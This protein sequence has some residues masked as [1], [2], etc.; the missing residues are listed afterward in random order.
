MAR[1]HVFALSDAAVVLSRPSTGSTLLSDYWWMT[2]P[3]VNFLIAVT[4]AAGFNMGTSVTPSPVPWVALVPTLVGTLLVASGAAALN[5]WMEYPFD[6]KMRRTARRAIAAGRIDPI[7]ALL[8]GALLSL[9]GLTYMFLA[10]GA[11]PSWL[12]LATLVGY[13]CFYT[14]LKRRTPLCTLV[15]AIP[16]AVPP[17]IGWTAAS[18]HL[19]PEAWVLFLIVFLWQFPHFMSIAWMYKDDYA[20]ASYLVLPGHRT[21]QRFAIVQTLLPLAGLLPVS[22]LPVRAGEASS[23]YSVGA[24][25]L[26]VGFLYVGAQFAVRVS[27]SA[28]RRLL[29]ASIIYLPA[30][31]ALMTFL[32]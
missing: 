15:G 11:L 7:H 3:E 24:V 21:R 12:A 30:L 23:L 27:P 13:L 29:M 5:Q 10:V 1:E 17:L 9:A 20:R 22:L 19:D 8:F 18:G 32:A 28:A 16:G 4:T 25:V 6:A 26:G 14:P 31:L 2:K